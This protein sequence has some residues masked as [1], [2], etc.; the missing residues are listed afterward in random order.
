MSTEEVTLTIPEIRAAARALVVG[1]VAGLA[2]CGLFSGISLAAGN[3]LFLALNVTLAVP[4]SL[5]L[6]RSIKYMKKVRD[7]CKYLAIH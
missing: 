4:S 6:Y 1:N 7:L 5:G 2:L 3:Y